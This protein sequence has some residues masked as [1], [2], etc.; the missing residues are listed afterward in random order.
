MASL[1][2]PQNFANG[3]TQS[4]HCFTSFQYVISK[5]EI[6]SYYMIYAY[7]SFLYGL[8]KAI[9][10]ISLALMLDVPR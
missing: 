1:E 7:S 9:H 8:F 2:K 5:A 3:K 4:S 6:C 10:T